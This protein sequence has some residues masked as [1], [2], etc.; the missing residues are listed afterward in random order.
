MLG[1]YHLK[2]YGRGL[3]A[4]RLAAMDLP[5]IV[6]LGASLLFVSAPALRFLHLKPWHVAA[7]A[8]GT[9]AVFGQLETER[10]LYVAQ[11]LSPALVSI[12]A[13]MVLSAVVSQSGLLQR[14]FLLLIR[15][16]RPTAV[17]VFNITFVM[18][19]VVSALLSN[20]LAILML[21]PSIIVYARTHFPDNRPVLIALVFAVFTA[22]GVAP[23]PTS[24]PMNLIFVWQFDIPLPDYVAAMGPVSLLIWLIS[25]C[26]V[27]LIFHKSL[28]SRASQESEHTPLSSFE[29][30][31]AILV[32]FQAAAYMAGSR[33]GIPIWMICIIFACLALA[34]SRR[35]LSTRSLVSTLDKDSLLFLGFIHL[36]TAGLANSQISNILEQL[37]GSGSL[38]VTA[39]VSALGSAMINNHPMAALSL[40]ALDQ[41]DASHQQALAAL[42]G[43]DIGPRLLV[44]GS[45]A[46]VLWMSC[47]QANN[48]KVSHYDFLRV[49]L[50][51]ALPPIVAG[52]LLL[53]WL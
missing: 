7:L 40:S 39:L 1:I 30:Q 41:L 37:Y 21:T 52:T 22:T 50:A 35:H 32:V 23:L 27:R 15:D 51:T 42:I 3:F 45:L 44:T 26:T 20:D 19:C 9:L 47:L 34:L 43:G 12:G 5:S 14:S 10:V 36:F 29:K 33:I 53:G 8:T 31:L 13:L 16:P 4:S 49:G 11:R 28:Q 48:V 2:E 38:M 6:F 24:N 46:G 17:S 18:T 25:W